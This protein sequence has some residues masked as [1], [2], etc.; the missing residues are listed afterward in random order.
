MWSCSSGF[1]PGPSVTPGGPA[2]KGFAGNN[3]RMKKNVEMPKSTASAHATSGS[4]RRCRYRIAT[5]A[6]NPPST[7]TQSRIDPS[8]ALQ[9]AVT[10][11]SAGVPRLPTCWM[12]FRLKSRV[13]SARS[14]ITN[15]S[16]AIPSTTH[17]Y[18]RPVRAIRWECVRALV[19]MAMAPNTDAE[20]PRTS[21]ALPTSPF[22]D[23]SMGQAA[24]GQVED[25]AVSIRDLFL[26]AY[27]FECLTSTSFPRNVPPDSRPRTTTGMHS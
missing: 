15:A 13:M 26:A 24:C 20:R 6:I 2:T 1:G 7:S 8:S 22:N 21:A 10:L 5:A 23:P 16:T 19:A 11:K 3:V 17:A 4:S 14:I 27:S 18:R 9:A 25:S 12:Y